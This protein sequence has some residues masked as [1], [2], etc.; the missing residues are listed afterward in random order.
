MEVDA[1]DAKD[2]DGLDDKDAEDDNDKDEDEDDHSFFVVTITQH[3]FKGSFLTGYCAFY[4]FD[5]IVERIGFLF[6]STYL[7]LARDLLHVILVTL[8]INKRPSKQCNTSF[9]ICES[10]ADNPRER[11]WLTGFGWNLELLDVTV[12][13]KMVVASDVGHDNFRQRYSV[14]E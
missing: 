1:D 12:V 10:F 14:G 5:E 2:D 13:T 7:R 11:K 4:V 6:C 9:S 3:N 8:F